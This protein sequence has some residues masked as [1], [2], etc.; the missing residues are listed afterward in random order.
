MGVG[1]AVYLLMTS[2]RM[3]CMGIMGTANKA[4]V[5]FFIPASINFRP[6][7]ESAAAKPI[8]IQKIF[9]AVRICNKADNC[10]GR[11]FSKRN[12]HLF[13]LKIEKK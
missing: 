9:K 7:R 4:K 10:I 5:S 1:P 8:C 12:I 2:G 6:V 13:N 3:I 11:N